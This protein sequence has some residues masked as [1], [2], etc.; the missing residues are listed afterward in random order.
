MNTCPCCSGQLL[1][2]TR[3]QG[4]YWFCMHCRQEMPFL[5]SDNIVSVNLVSRNNVFQFNQ[6]SLLSLVK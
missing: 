3:R 6:K 5:A 1:R 4:L 2:H